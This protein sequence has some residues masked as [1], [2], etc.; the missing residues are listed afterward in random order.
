MAT[1]PAPTTA[2]HREQRSDKEQEKP[3]D[4]LIVELSKRRSSGQIKRLRKG[5]GKL[6][7]DIGEVVDDLI[8]SGTIKSGTPPVVIVV[9]EQA[10]TMF[11]P[12]R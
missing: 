5:R 9:R 10:D 12:L 1:Q 11:W 2:E 6:A 8:A 3:R 7:R 4:L